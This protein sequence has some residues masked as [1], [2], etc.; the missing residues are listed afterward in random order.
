MRTTKQLYRVDRRQI[1][2][3][4]FIFE[5]YEGLA[6]VTTVDSAAGVVSLSVAPGCED[7]AKAI[8]DDLAR[9]ILIE[10]LR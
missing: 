10:P 8:M 5:A 2:M 9:D 3:I 7:T 4:R 6:V 1:S